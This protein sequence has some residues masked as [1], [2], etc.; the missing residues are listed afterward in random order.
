VKAIKVQKGAILMKANVERIRLFVIITA[1]VSSLIAVPVM[2]QDVVKI[3]AIFS[4][5]G[6][7][8]EVA[9][10]QKRAI[11]M[12]IKEIN[13]SGGVD[14]G[15]KKMK[16]EA[17]FGDDQTKPETATNL[18][19]DMV[20]NK[21]VTAV[22]AG[23]AAHIPGALNIAAKKDKALLIAACA[24]PD[25]Y[26]E[27]KVKA[28]TA[29]GIVVAG[30]DIGRAGASYVAEK[31]KPKKV[32][33]FVPAYAFGN[34]LAAGFEPVIKKYPEITY[35]IFWHPFGSTNIKR[36][37]EAVRD[38]RPDVIV[39]GSWGQDAVNA[40]NSAFEMGLGKTSKLFHLWTVNAMAA[41]IRPEAMKGIW[42][43]IFWLHDMSGFRDESVVKATNEF[44]AN[45]AKLYNEP[46]DAYALASYDAVKE[47]ARAIKLSQSTDPTKMYEALMA[48][49][50]W[51]GAK[52]EAKWRKDGRCMYKYFD[53]IVEGKGPDERK[54]GAFGNKYDY[55]KVVD[56]FTGDAFAPTLQELG[57]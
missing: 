42:A 46:P 11:E 1:L 43:Q 36:D 34:A 18:F 5:T 20:K 37:L 51:T 35:K 14:V 50:D 24:T 6:P 9:K 29:L 25:T 7:V 21:Q 27:Q 40:F 45:Y 56:V 32:A 30:S 28:P 39:I 48:N 8:A 2:A 49:P 33:C 54:D 12:A 4:L 38:F 47:V 23:T 52:G 53:W 55:A 44:S 57:Y 3:G 16:I 41:A 15:A 17:L 10:V 26:H 31:I 13:D 19:E 22:I